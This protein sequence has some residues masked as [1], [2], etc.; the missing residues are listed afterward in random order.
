MRDAKLGA[1][2][3]WL[4]MPATPPIDAMCRTF[5]RVSSA[6]LHSRGAIA[7]TFGIAC[8]VR[9]RASSSARCRVLPPHEGGRCADRRQLSCGHQHAPCRA[10][11]GLTVP[12]CCVEGR[13]EPRV[14]EDQGRLGGVE[15]ARSEH[16][17]YH[18]GDP[19]R[20]DSSCTYRSQSDD[21]FP[22]YRAWSA[23]RWPE[24][25]ACHSQHGRR[26][27]SGLAHGNGRL[28]RAWFEEA[29]AGHRRWRSGA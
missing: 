6:S 20:N 14:A 15:Q 2:R 8:Q 7:N 11:S 24:S 3:S 17:R 28:D 22:A 29:G 18:S 23:S 1:T 26:E 16:G 25:S 13:G 9:R 12:G 10:C 21:D 19:R 4:F 27:R 5:S